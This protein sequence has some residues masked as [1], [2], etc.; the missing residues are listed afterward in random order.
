MLSSEKGIFGNLQG[1]Q[2]VLGV[3][4]QILNKKYWS[5]L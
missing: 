2:V 3:Q 4:K 1:A 5:I